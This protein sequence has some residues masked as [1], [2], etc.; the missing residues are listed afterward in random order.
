MPSAWQDEP[1]VRALGH[2][3]LWHLVS[4]G[5][6]LT[7]AYPPLF[8]IIYGV[9]IHALLVFGIAPGAIAARMPSVMIGA[10]TV[11]FFFAMFRRGFGERVALIGATFLA[12]S[13]AHLT[14]SHIAGPEALSVFLLVAALGFTTRLLDR[15]EAYCENEGHP[16]GLWRDGT[17]RALAAGYAASAILLGY[18]D[19]LGFAVLLFSLTLVLVNLASGRLPIATT[20]RI[21]VALNLAIAIALLPMLWLV[22]HDPNAGHDWAS[23][24]GAHEAIARVLLTLIDFA[25]PP[26]AQ[27]PSF[28]VLAAIMIAET[29]LV[30]GCYQVPS[31]GSRRAGILIGFLLALVL[32]FACGSWPSVLIAAAPSIFALP[33]FA[34][35]A[36]F[37]LEMPFLNRNA[38][39]GV[40]FALLLLGAVIRIS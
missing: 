31:G 28:V 34:L 13:P 32:V 36:G 29:L 38:H 19:N 8:S 40:T 16:S 27:A 7:G 2:E 6:P 30:V 33:F 39:A 17:F 14:F 35:L 15:M 9:W 11:P 21:W 26:A 12:A 4:R 20:T 25:G 5:S 3:N 10:L 37:A 22:L 18:I 1:F 23:H 24:I